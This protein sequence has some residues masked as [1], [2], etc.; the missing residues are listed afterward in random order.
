MALIILRCVYILVAASIA[1]SVTNLVPEI[2]AN[3]TL[4][5]LIFGGTLAL[6]LLVIGLDSFVKKKR[7][8][9]ITAVYFGLLIGML[10]T[11]VLGIALT[12]LLKGSKYQD[13]VQ[14]LLGSVLSYSCV[15]L[16]IQTKDDFRFIIPYVEFAKEVKGLKP[17][18]LDTSAV[19]DGRIADVVDTQ[20]LDNQL[21]MPRFVLGELQNIADSN[22]RM[23]RG[24]GRRGL[25]ILNRLRNNELVDFQIHDR[26]CRTWKVRQWI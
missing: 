21:V 19:I 10:L 8:D 7:I 26:E 23:R 18:V 4:V 11:Y 17:L 22:D 6:S 24:R 16:L 3:P 20:M 9:T 2:R 13:L 12:P 25:D 15:S 1:V 14:L 5:W